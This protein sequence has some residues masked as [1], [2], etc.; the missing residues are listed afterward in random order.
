MI[1]Q[2]DNENNDYDN[3]EWQWSLYMMMAR[4]DSPNP[5]EW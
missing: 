2:D 4:K 1:V 3:G 5:W